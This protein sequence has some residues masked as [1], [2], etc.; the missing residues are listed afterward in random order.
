[1]A[2]RTPHSRGM[3]PPCDLCTDRVSPF[4]VCG[5]GVKAESEHARTPTPR[6]RLLLFHLAIETVRRRVAL[7]R[8]SATTATRSTATD[9]RRRARSSRA[10]RAATESSTRGAASSAIRPER[11]ARSSARRARERSARGRSHSAARSS[12]PLSAPVCHSASSRGASTWS[13]GASTRTGLLQSSSAAP[14]FTRPRF[15]TGSSERSAC[16][17]TPAPARS[18]ATANAVDTRWS[19]Q[20]G[21][22]SSRLPITTPPGSAKGAAGALS[23]RLTQKFVQPSWAGKRLR[24]RELSETGTIVT[25]TAEPKVL[26]ER[27]SEIGTAARAGGRAFDCAAGRRRRCGKLAARPRRGGTTRRRR[28]QSQTTIEVC[29]GLECWANAPKRRSTSR[30]RRL[31]GTLAPRPFGDPTRRRRRTEVDLA[32]RARSS[33]LRQEITA[34]RGGDRWAVFD[35]IRPRHVTGRIPEGNAVTCTARRSSR[36]NEEGS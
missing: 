21:P 3:R 33:R 20:H 15:S 6:V 4:P 19:G 36:V 34:Y 1:M 31:E 27:S 10:P 30:T 9:V 18:T 16:A 2:R 14:S 12:P 11:V 7:R 5:D 22:G 28:A 23:A 24:E 32:R 35:W 25:R 13:A 26:P 17:S 29:D 8:R